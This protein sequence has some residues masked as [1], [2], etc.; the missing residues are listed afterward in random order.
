MMV[1]NEKGDSNMTNRKP[2]SSTPRWVKVFG[3]IVIILVLF[4]V[5]MMITG[6]H[7]P[8]RHMPSDN[9]RDHT[10]PIETEDISY[11]HDTKNT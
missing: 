10:L 1:L 2:N 4:V 9:T 11:D 7:G 6:N 3:I 8:G 5:I